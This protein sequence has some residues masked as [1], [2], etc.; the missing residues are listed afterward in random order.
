MDFIFLSQARSFNFHSI[1]LPF[2]ILLL[3]CVSR[4]VVVVVVVDIPF[5]Y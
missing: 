3:F 2:E 4:W 1:T 5:G